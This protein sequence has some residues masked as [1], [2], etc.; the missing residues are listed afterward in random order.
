M[1]FHYAYHAG[2][3]CVHVISSDNEIPPEHAFIKGHLP[4]LH[5]PREFPLVFMSNRIVINVFGIMIVD[6]S[7]YEKYP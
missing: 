7:R 6:F 3:Q 2:K 1:Y 5:V 4:L